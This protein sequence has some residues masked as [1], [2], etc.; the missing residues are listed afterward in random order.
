M[1]PIFFFVKWKKKFKKNKRRR[2]KKINKEDEMHLRC[3]QMSHTNEGICMERNKMGQSQVKSSKERETRVHGWAYES[4]CTEVVILRY[5][6]TLF[7]N[8][9]RVMVMK[10]ND[11]YMC[12]KWNTQLWRSRNTCE[13]KRERKNNN[14]KKKKRFLVN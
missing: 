6:S 3:F 14:N 11:V 7:M 10:K 1:C 12:R 2:R 13:Q 8:V 4:R 5:C 9:F